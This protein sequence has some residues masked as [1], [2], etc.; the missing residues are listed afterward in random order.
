MNKLIVMGN[1][2]GDPKITHTDSTTIAKYTV[3]V[4]RRG[5]REENIADY[6]PC[7]AFGRS[8]EFAE[9]YLHQGMKMLITGRLQSGSYINKD[10]QKVYTL[11]LVVEDQEFAGS[12]GNNKASGKEG[13]NDIRNTPSPIPDAAPATKKSSNSSAESYDENGFMTTPI[14]MNNLPFA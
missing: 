6:I 14:D 7:V 13:N 9:K 8:A 5:K 11:D 3:A 10:G 4:N 12:K 1:L 2:T